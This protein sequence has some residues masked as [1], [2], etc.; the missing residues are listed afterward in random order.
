MGFVRNLA[1]FL[2]SLLFPKSC[3]VCDSVFSE[4]PHAENSPDLSVSLCQAC[5]EGFI[6]LSPPDIC[7]LCGNPLVE[8]HSNSPCGS[9]FVSQKHFSIAR[10]IVL[11]SGPAARVAKI[12]KYDGRF[13]LG[14]FFS[15]LV[16][17]F[18]P[19]DM[20]DFEVVIPVPLHLNRI[21]EREFN[22]SAVISS[23]VASRLGK[24]HAPSAL[25][26]VINTTPQVSFSKSRDRKANMRGAFAITDEGKK[27]VKNKKVLLFD[28]I[29]TTGSTLD[30]C[31]ATLL[32]GGA[33]EV[34]A[35]TVF[36]TPI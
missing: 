9:C 35:L 12:F 21:R 4:P 27:A 3:V 29:F 13:S 16:V 33:A 5:A 6:P 8:N 23:K 25:K 20:G 24:K 34:K 22:Q 19:S 17:D 31:S 11:F 15:S 7:P 2:I 30:E 14:T 32:S 10:S 26:R 18:F 36:R 28:D 1:S